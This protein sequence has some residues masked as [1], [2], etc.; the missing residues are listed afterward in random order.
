MNWKKQIFVIIAFLI[1]IVNSGV[2]FNVH[3]CEDSIASVEINY[4]RTSA[5]EEDD[6]CGAVEEP[7]DCC[8][9]KLI[10]ATEKSDQIVVKTPAFN[11]DFFVVPQAYNS[12][13]F[14]SDSGNIKRELVTYF[15]DAN[16]P[17]LYLLYHQLTF[18]C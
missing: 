9:D 5:V 2:S 14:Y 18:Y 15:C 17:P 3:Y 1:L 13:F 16:A 6:C 12:L 7:T 8:S 4:I 11:L 10:K